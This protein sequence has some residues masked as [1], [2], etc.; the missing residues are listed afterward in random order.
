M[1]SLFLF[2]TVWIVLA[3]T[4]S[5]GSGSHFISEPPDLTSN[6][7]N[8]TAVGTISAG[9]TY[10]S[11]S[12]DG[13]MDEFGFESGDVADSFEFVVPANH[14]VTS[15]KL[16]ITNFASTERA[17][18]YLRNFSGGTSSH[19]FSGDTTFSNLVN[20]SEGLG[21]G[22]YDLQIATYF[23]KDPETYQGIGSLSLDWKL[24]FTVET[25][26]F[27]PNDQVGV[28]GGGLGIELIDDDCIE[29]M[30]DGASRADDRLTGIFTYSFT[31]EYT[32]LANGTGNQGFTGLQLYDGAT[33]KF[34]VGTNFFSSNWG[35]YGRPSGDFNFDLLDSTNSTVP[36][37]TGS[38]EDITVTIKMV[39]GSDD[40]I[41][42]N[43][44]GQDNVFTGPVSFDQ[45]RL[46][47]G[48]NTVNVTNIQFEFSAPQAASVQF[49]S[50]SAPNF[51]FIATELDPDWDYGV[52]GTN[53]ING[54][55]FYWGGIGG[56]DTGYPPFSL[57]VGSEDQYFIQLRPQP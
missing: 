9:T 57:P 41:T 36:L 13:Y 45:V 30:T 24:V 6:L 38:S 40:S 5:F 26:G 25:D 39:A 11:G 48:G 29:F 47:S 18:G 44:R 22:T 55:W 42:V 19:F 15:I 49:V 27:L 50:Y 54:D 10:L 35:G 28:T 21:P 8:P 31:M 2:V 1:R 51:L 17:E 33:E 4:P 34:A 52:Y 20:V 56:T 23:E 32:A 12:I 7:A 46:R 3:V 37:S 14:R 16:E 43:F 53:D